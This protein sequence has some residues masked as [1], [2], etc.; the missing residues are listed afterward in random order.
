MVAM[1]QQVYV[2]LANAQLI[3]SNAIME[4]VFS[5]HGFAMVR[6]IVVTIVTKISSMDAR[7]VNNL[8]SVVHSNM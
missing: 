8:L 6:M 1:S 4:D 2:A 7:R 5:I 3:I